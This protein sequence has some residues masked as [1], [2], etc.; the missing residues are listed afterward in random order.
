MIKQPQG[1][2]PPRLDGRAAIVTGAGRGIGRALALRLA[3]EGANV[4]I[5]DVDAANAQ[6]AKDEITASGGS[7]IAVV[8]DVSR[9]APVDELLDAAKAAFGPVEILINHAGRIDF[10]RHFL[11]VDEAWWDLVLTTNLKSMYLCS[12]AVA[13]DMVELGRGV[14][15]NTSSGGATRAHRGNAPYD[16]AKGG[17][18]ALTR[19]LALD[20]APY[21]IRVNAIAPGAIDVALPG[22]VSDDDLAARARR[23]RLVASAHRR[24]WQARWRSWCPTTQRT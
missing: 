15:I 18:E 12:R 16:A 20:L 19:A 23:F 8:A 21:G 2:V 6:S 11:E 10:A 17:I 5:A 9:K 1:A 7:A 13:P 22:T 3:A 4:V 14:I 24:T